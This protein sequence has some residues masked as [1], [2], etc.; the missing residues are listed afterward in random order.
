MPILELIIGPMFAGKSCELIRRIRI[1]KVLNKKYIVVS[2]RIDDR[3][4]NNMIVSHN[5]DKEQ[6]IKLNNL[7]DIYSHDLNIDTIFI[8]EGQF[9]SD[10]IVVKDLVETYNINVIVSGLIGDSNR[11]QFGQI[12]DLLPLADNIVTLKAMC[13]LCMDGTHGIFSHRKQKITDQI[14]IGEK[15]TYSSLCRKHYLELN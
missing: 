14:L 15:D 8:D 2:P 1:L 13:L 5:F 7:Q 11:K 12:V 10:L 3:Y 6:C 4:D 9:F